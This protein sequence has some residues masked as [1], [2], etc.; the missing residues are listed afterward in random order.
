MS[1]TKIGTLAVLLASVATA[2]VAN[3]DN[4]TGRLD[5]TGAQAVQAPV[6]EGRQ[7]TP[8]APAT[9]NSADQLLLK[10]ATDQ[11]AVKINQN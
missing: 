7:A 9:Q 3:P 8:I 4:A 5:F 1:V 2:A 6:V 11:E 10:R